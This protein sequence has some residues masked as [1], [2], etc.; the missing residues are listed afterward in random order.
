MEH[1]REIHQG[2]CRCNVCDLFTCS[3]CHGSEG[4]LP[5]ECPGAVMSI[6]VQDLVAAGK[7]DFVDGK[8]IQLK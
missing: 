5:R 2:E 8:W 4:S 6:K 1:I 7:I 3:V